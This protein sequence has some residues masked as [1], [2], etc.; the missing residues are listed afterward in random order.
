[1]ESYEKI[2]LPEVVGKGYKTFWEFKGRY[3]ITKGGRG[4]KKSTTASLWYIYNMMMYFHQYGLKPHTLVIRR[5]YNTHKDSTYAQL[6]WAI[7]RL[8]VNHLWKHT[9]SPLQLVYKPSGQKILFRGMDDPQSITSITVEEGHLCWVWWE[10]AFQITLESDFDKVDMSIRGDTPYPLFKQ[11]TLTFNPWSDKIW[12][13]KRFFDYRSDDIV[14]LTKNYDCN[15]FLDEAD[16]HIFEVMRTDNPRRY[17]IE[18]LGGWGISEGL[19]YENWKE[20]EFDYELML[21]QVDA[22]DRPR[23][24]PLNG[25]DFG[26]TN[27]PT[28]FMA[29]LADEKG[30]KLYIYDEI[31]KTRL[32]NKDIYDTLKYKG[33][34]RARICADSEDPRTIDELIDLGISRMFGAKKG[35]GSVKAGIQKLQDYE[36]IVHPRCP[37]TIVELSNYI[38]ATD[39]DTGKPS[40]E[41]QDEYNHLMDAMRYATEELNISTFSW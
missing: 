38:W 33:F 13:K 12:I 10:E 20:M 8:K 26:Y 18:G 4:S 40:I 19:I 36:I 34:E 35:K 29:I 25:L 27:D 9:T 1:M 30:R 24:R 14:A 2:N 22:Y 17:Q 11:H 16:R 39:R 23:Y 7:N 28:A 15:E 41:P 32:K 5:Y 6:R 21:K 31:Y 37:N 3:R